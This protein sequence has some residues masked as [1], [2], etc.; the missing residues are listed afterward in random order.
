[1]SNAIKPVSA[2][3][4]LNAT[5][6]GNYALETALGQIKKAM[7]YKMCAAQQ[8]QL[9]RAVRQIE[10]TIKLATSLHDEAAAVV[11]QVLSQTVSMAGKVTG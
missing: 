1:M 6:A 11:D 2:V 8:E 10:H 5:T 4:V 3:H 7:T 9:E